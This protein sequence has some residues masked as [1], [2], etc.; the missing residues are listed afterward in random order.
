MPWCHYSH[1][2]EM[3]QCALFVTGKTNLEVLG[4]AGGGAAERNL[5]IRPSV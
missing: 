5:F 3:Y 4:M 2:H 1:L